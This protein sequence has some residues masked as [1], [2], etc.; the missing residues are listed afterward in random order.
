MKILIEKNKIDDTVK[1]LGTRISRD[2]ADKNPVMV[3]VLKGAFMFMA[4]LLRSIDIPCEVDFL[5]I[6][7][8]NGK[9]SSGVVR[10]LSDLT[11]DITGR[12]VI[13]VEDII[14]TGRTVTY[15]LENL[16]TRKPES[17]AVCTLLDKQEARQVDIGLQYV[18]FTI[19]DVFV[20]GYGLDYDQNYRH[21]NY[22]GV[23]DGSE[24][25]A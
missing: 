10:L 20:V 25:T 15:I 21:L 12:H 23:L 16:H 11:V 1:N 19:P 4:D 7:S 24:S 14:D 13:L 17:L 18:G 6:Q 8:Y 2:Y 3:G 22:I 5:S 9:S